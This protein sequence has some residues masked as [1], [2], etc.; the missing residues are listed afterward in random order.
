[1]PVLGEELLL[2]L[3]VAPTLV[4]AALVQDENWI[5]RPIYYI[6]HVMRDAETRYI[7]IEK[8]LV[9]KLVSIM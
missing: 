8:L 4:S 6:R 9:L 2:N 5:Q 7:K 1:M 3:S